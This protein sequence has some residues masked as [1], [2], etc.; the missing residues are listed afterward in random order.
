MSVP[1][2]T[3]RGPAPFVSA[4][5][6]M[7]REEGVNVT[8]APPVEERGIGDAAVEVVLYLGDQAVSGLMG[9]GIA[10]VLTKFN[11]RFGDSG[12]SAEVNDDD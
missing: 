3:Y 10:T 5:A 8:Y 6:Q 12:A 1:T 2:I 7:L 4:L 9:A 11:K